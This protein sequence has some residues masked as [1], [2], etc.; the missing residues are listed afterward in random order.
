MEVSDSYSARQTISGCRAIDEIKPKQ[1]AHR[2]TLS[3]VFGYN[4]VNWF[5]EVHIPLLQMNLHECNQEINRLNL[6][7]ALDFICYFF[8]IFLL[9]IE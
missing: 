7:V 1:C 5:V 4:K 2:A 9:C 8:W 3:R 6:D